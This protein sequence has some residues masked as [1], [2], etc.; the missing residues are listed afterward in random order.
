[1]IT[2]QETALM[3]GL[4]AEQT[5]A[6]LL[7]ELEMRLARAEREQREAALDP[8]LS[9]EAHRALDETIARL[10]DQHRRLWAE[11]YP[12]QQSRAG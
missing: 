7:R 5:E 6:V 9:L 8:T 12:E 1:M 4:G 10:E 2:M 3:L 11:V